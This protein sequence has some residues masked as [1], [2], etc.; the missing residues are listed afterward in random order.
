MRKLLRQ[1][2]K[3][4]TN[5][6]RQ[7]IDKEAKR[8]NEFN[9]LNLGGTLEKEVKVDMDGMSTIR[10]DFVASNLRSQLNRLQNILNNIEV[11]DRVDCQ[12]TDISLKEIEVVLRQIRKVC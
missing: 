7:I 5:F 11:S 4:I 8:V 3:P 1:T 2:I 12:Y 9:N 10:K 6:F